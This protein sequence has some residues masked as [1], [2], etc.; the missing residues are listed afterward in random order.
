MAGFFWWLQGW[1]VVHS[2]QSQRKLLGV[3]FNAK[4][5]YIT[6]LYDQL[7]YKHFTYQ[8]NMSLDVSLK[9]ITTR[10]CIKITKITTFCQANF[11]QPLFVCQIASLLTLRRRLVI[12]CVLG[13]C[14]SFGLDSS[15]GHMDQFQHGWVHILAGVH[16]VHFCN[17]P[18]Y[19]KKIAK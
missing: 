16:G 3:V 7:G 9:Y 15:S 14:A 19:M 1:R 10:I 17:W 12:G 5:M 11:I 13:R 8:I 2:E 6:R 4:I 18:I